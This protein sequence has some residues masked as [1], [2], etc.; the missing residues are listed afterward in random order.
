MRTSSLP[1][2]PFSRSYGVILPSSLTIVLSITLEFSSW[3]PVSVSGTGT[4]I[5]SPRSFSWKFGVTSVRQDRSLFFPI[6]FQ[7]ICITHLTVY[8]PLCLDQNPLI[9]LILPPSS[10]L[11]LYRW[12]RINYLLSIGYALWPHLR[13]WLTLGRRTLPR[14]PWSFGEWDF[15]P[16]FVTHTGILT[17]NRSNTPYG[18]SSLQLE[19]SPTTYIFWYKSAASVLC[20][21]PVHLRRSF[22]RLVSYYALFKGWLLLSQPPSCFYNSTS[23][24]T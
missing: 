4:Y 2:H 23:F 14:N 11:Q 10:L 20:L 17:S 6:T 24:S 12:Y 19:R 16:F 1:D 15:H 18:I 5:I 21:A 8:K 13:S 7:L 3:P 22:T 9:G